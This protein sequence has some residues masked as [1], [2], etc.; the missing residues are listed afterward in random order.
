MLK[1]FKLSSS[2]LDC[3][4]EFTSVSSDYFFKL[5]GSRPGLAEY[6][7]KSPQT[8]KIQTTKQKQKQQK[9]NQ[10]IKKKSLTQPYAKTLLIYCTYI[11]I[12][13]YKP[14]FL[15]APISFYQLLHDY[16]LEFF[17]LLLK[18]CN[19][20]FRKMWKQENHL[21]K[22]YY[23][24]CPNINPRQVTH[25]WMCWSY[26]DLMSYNL[27][28]ELFWITVCMILSSPLLSG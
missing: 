7:Q 26:N 18:R 1:D 8:K 27:S 28:V 16:W 22:K 13:P 25:L 24:S 4:D 14:S 5:V 23:L 11:Y 15:R 6:N 2:Y 20:T 12:P 17:Y 3:M 10:P 21:N 19:E 9:N